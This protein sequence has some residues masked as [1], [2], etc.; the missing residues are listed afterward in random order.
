MPTPVAAMHSTDI[1][2]L[3][4]GTGEAGELGEWAAGFRTRD[5]VAAA[6]TTGDGAVDIGADEKVR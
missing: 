3:W 5:I 2:G 6:E 4:P 1:L